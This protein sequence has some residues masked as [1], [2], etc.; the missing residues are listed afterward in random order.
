MAVTR[1]APLAST[2]GDAVTAPAWRVK[3][4]WY[5]V[6][7]QGRMI[8]P[9][10]ERRMAARMNPRKTVELEAGH[11]PLASQPHAVADPIEAAA[12]PSPAPDRLPT[13]AGPGGPARPRLTRG[14]RAAQR[15]SVSDQAPGRSVHVRRR[16]GPATSASAR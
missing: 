10:S 5:Q 6:S 4:T 3:P 14:R 12:P 1:K 15:G 13:G 2:F 8:H 9:D 7:A 11:A 16:T